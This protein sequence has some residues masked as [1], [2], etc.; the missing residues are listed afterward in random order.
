VEGE[1]G[2]APRRVAGS[3]SSARI[4]VKAATAAPSTTTQFPQL[5]GA[6][7]SLHSWT[8]RQRAITGLTHTWGANISIVECSHPP[9]CTGA[10]VLAFSSVWHSPLMAPPLLASTSSCVPFYSGTGDVTSNDRSGIG[11]LP[12][13]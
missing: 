4:S 11:N 9:M 7:P 12:L 8:Q 3:S 1:G 10:G 5:L 6:A 2:P 13:S